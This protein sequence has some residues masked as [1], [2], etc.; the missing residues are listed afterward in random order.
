MAIAL[1]AK[2]TGITIPWT[3]W[4]KGFLPVGIVLTLIQ[5]ALLYVIY[6]P[7]LKEAPEAPRW[8]AGQLKSLGAMTRQEITMLLLVLGALGFWIAGA[9]YV[10]PAIV[11]ASKAIRRGVAD[12]Q[13]GTLLEESPGDGR[14]DAAPGAGDDRALALEPPHA[15]TPGSRMGH[16]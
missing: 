2:A 16:P 6:P 8:A 15:G 13:P 5:P 12:Q 11:A 4:F 14:A 1:I 3:L 7:Q 10:D 9:A